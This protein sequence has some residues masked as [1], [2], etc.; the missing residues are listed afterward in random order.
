MNDLKTAE[1]NTLGQVNLN[2]LMFWHIAAK[3]LKAEEVPVLEIL[4]EFRELAGA[5]GRN[6]HKPTMPP[7]YDFRVKV[8][9]ES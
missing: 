2:N 1:R 5:F 8:E 9:V 6:A 3:H 7:S 4:A